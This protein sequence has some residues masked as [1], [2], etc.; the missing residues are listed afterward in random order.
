MAQILVPIDF[1]AASARALEV[2]SLFLPKLASKLVVYHA[3]Q[4]GRD[5]PFL[6]VDKIHSMEKQAYQEARKRVIEFAKAHSGDKELAYQPIVQQEFFLDGLLQQLDARRYRFVLIGSSSEEGSAGLLGYNAENLIVRSPVP[7]G[8]AFPSTEIKA[9]RRFLVIF[10]PEG[11]RASKT[12]ILRKIVQA[13][14]V[15]V[16]GMPLLSL[17]GVVTRLH[18]RMQ[19][20][21]DAPS[22]ENFRWG[23]EVFAETLL[24]MATVYDVDMVCILVEPTF[25]LEGLRQLQAT[26][27]PR[28]LLFFVI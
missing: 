22:Y 1:S 8:L 21:L 18:Q 17:S 14:G 3:Y 19:R 10:D 15:H 7:V 26:H 16:I 11:L 6:S 24:R 27:L 13:Y 25:V 4:L 9:L 2:A 23:S 5:Y 12:R 20:N 28:S